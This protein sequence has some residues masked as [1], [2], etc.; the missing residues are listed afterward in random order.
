MGFSNMIGKYHLVRTIGEGTFAKIK[1]AI[2]TING[3]KVAIKII[4][5]H[6]IKQ[7]N[8]IYQVKREIRAMKLLNHPNIVQIHEVIGTK[9]KIYIVMEYV[10]GGPLSDQM[11]YLTRLEEKE[12]RKYFQQFIDAVG[13]CHSKG[14]YHRDLKPQ[15]LLL[16]G[17]GNIK[18]SDFGLSTL[19]KA[20]SLLST[21]C[22]SPSY[23]SPELLSQ[24]GYEGEA[25]DIWSCG[26][27]RAKCMFPRWFTEDQKKLISR[28]LDPNPKTRITI[29]EIIEDEWFQMEPV[30]RVE[31]KQHNGKDDRYTTFNVIKETEGGYDVDERP[32]FINAFRLIAMSHDLDLSRLFEEE[33]MEKEKITLGSK[34]TIDETIEKIKAAAEH[35]R[36]SA[37]R[38]DKCKLQI[39][40]SKMI[41]ASNSYIDLTAQVV[42]LAPNHCAIEITKSEGELRL[43]KQF[44]KSLSSMLT[45][46]ERCLK[47]TCKMQ[48]LDED[49]QD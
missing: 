36:L 33:D 26:I 27:Y 37:E 12:A 43:Y 21:T 15:N 2:N 48:K 19:A 35:V 28:I 5:K 31:S 4:D 29:A 23:V 22:G 8:L 7:N 6:M 42:E 1:L 39:H 16:D 9:T 38:I 11:S 34:H 30:V 47:K 40:P 24:K 46:E 14:V 32:N 3:E 44:C 18:V 45:K 20:S 17:K 25:A 13:H 49:Q 41:K 10:P